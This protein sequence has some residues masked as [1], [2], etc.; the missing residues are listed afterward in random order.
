MHSLKMSTDDDY[1]KMSDLIS[2]F[3]V[4]LTNCRRVRKWMKENG[5]T[6]LQNYFSEFLN[7]KTVMWGCEE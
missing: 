2:E 1:K 4:C 5:K 7:T 6:S 3:Y